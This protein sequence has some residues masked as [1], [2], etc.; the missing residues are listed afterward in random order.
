MG[1][2]CAVFLTILAGGLPLASKRPSTV[3]CHLERTVVFTLLSR[4]LSV[5][6]E[7]EVSHQFLKLLIL[8]CIHAVLHLR[9][10]VYAYHTITRGQRK[11]YYE[12]NKVL[13]RIYEL[14]MQNTH[15]ENV[16][17]SQAPPN[18]S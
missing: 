15:T 18:Q 4:R 13:E 6:T 1:V 3:F 8:L 2:C 14:Q 12:C 10:R 7:Y 9:V 11:G 5:A 17:V 16:R